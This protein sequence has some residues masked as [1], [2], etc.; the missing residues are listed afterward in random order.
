MALIESTS[1]ALVRIT[2]LGIICFNEKKERAEIAV[3]RDEQHEL[4]I[5]IQQPKY[6]DG[7]DKD[8]IIYENIASY[9]GLP[10]ENVSIEILTNGESKHKGYEVYKADG[11][12]DRKDSEDM[13]D[14]R[15][16]VS[17]KKL[18]DENIVKANSENRYP[19]TK[20]F[21]NDGLFYVHQLNTDMVF[22]KIEKGEDGNEKHR[23][24]FGNIA[25]TL[26]VKLDADE[27]I[28]NITI[29]DNI[30]SHTLKRSGLPYRIEIKN[31]NYDE[32]AVLSDMPDYYKYIQPGT[33]S[34]YEFELIADDEASAKGISGKT[35]C[36][37]IEGG[38]GD[39]SSILELE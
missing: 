32:E 10:K 31:M 7:I 14:F 34:N 6:K 15:W 12:F 18:H 38:G 24:V 27:V 21:V 23:E 29:G 20:L 1:T 25:E 28:F 22:E 35:F 16:V 11:E 2:G 5:N 17:M 9:T 39:F 19:L 13:N 30:E 36:H 3:I 26:G 4:S 33:G 8:L 37:I